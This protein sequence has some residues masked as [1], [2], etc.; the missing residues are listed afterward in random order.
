LVGV[1]AVQMEIVY[2][3][4]KVFLVLQTQVAVQVVQ[5]ILQQ[6]AMAVQA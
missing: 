3:Q 1:V 2:M 6:V 4:Q 5:V